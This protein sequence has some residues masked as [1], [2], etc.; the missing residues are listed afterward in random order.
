MG[1]DLSIANYILIKVTWN[2]KKGELILGYFYA[3]FPAIFE[4]KII[5]SSRFLCITWVFLAGFECR[6]TYGAV[7][8]R[9][10]KYEIEV[11]SGKLSN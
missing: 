10:K 3:V 4:L 5:T 8:N 1:E 9:I 2:A 7:T 11:C 6:L